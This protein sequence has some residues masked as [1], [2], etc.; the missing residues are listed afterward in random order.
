[1]L[2]L[3]LVLLLL[4]MALL[5]LLPLLPLLLLLAACSSGCSFTKANASCKGIPSSTM[6]TTLAFSPGDSA[7]LRLIATGG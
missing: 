6:D 3:L 1:M 4:L 2:L 5:P 7:E